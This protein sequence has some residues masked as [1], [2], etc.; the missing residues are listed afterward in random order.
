MLLR[1]ALIAVSVAA[2]VVG[3]RRQ[4]A[5]QEDRGDIPVSV[6]SDTTPQVGVFDSVAVAIQAL[7]KRTREIQRQLD[8]R[9]RELAELQRRIERLEAA[10]R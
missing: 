1:H 9:N 8:A 3:C 5:V 10:R 4:P 2:M 6:S 7:E